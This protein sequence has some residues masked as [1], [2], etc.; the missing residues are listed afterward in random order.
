MNNINILPQSHLQDLPKIIGITGK[1]YNGKDTIANYLCDNYGYTRIAYGDPLKE[2]CRIL[3]GFDDNQLYGDDKEKIDNRW[4]ISPRQAF[5]FIGTDLLRNQMHL[6]LP[7][8]NDKIWIKCLIELLNKK[9][10]ENPNAKYIISDVRFQ[11]EIDSIKNEY[12]DSKIFRVIRPSVNIEQILTNK[13]SKIINVTK[14]NLTSYTTETQTSRHE[15]EMTDTLENIDYDIL[16]DSDL[17]SLYS[18]IENIINK[19]I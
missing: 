17:Q 1:K 5:Q 16:N 6:L 15:S 4:K 13:E 2:I 12:V 18:K 14:D 11:N 10:K 8:L 3:F 19:T 9:L 7:E